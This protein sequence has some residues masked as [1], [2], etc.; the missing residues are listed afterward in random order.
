MKEV[1]QRLRKSYT[2]IRRWK[3]QWNWAERAGAWDNDI[4]EAAI[5]KASGEY[6]RMLESQI[7]IGRML[8][9]KAANALLSMNFDR[10]EIKH[11]PSLLEMINSGVKIERTSREMT[12]KAAE[13]NQRQNLTINIIS[14]EKPFGGEEV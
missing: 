10:A 3:V 12:E 11:L 8:Q 5:K 13:K 1:A 7:N 6:A 2:I 4:A 14:R 9:S